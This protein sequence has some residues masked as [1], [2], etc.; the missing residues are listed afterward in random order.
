MNLKGKALGLAA[1]AAIAFG[2]AGSVSAE[3][4]TAD[5]DPNPTGQCSA[6]V[7]GGNIDFGTY[8]WN[9]SGYAAPGTTPSFSLSI[10]QNIAP[11]AVCDVAVQ[12]TDLDGPGTSSIPVGQVTLSPQGTGSVA[13]FTLATTD[14][15]LY[16]DT[17]GTQTVDAS[18]N[19]GALALLPTGTYTGTLTFTATLATP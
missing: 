6:A 14:H 5:L 7:S 19:T 4:T 3:T 18:I 17:T 2:F 11:E 15:S 10:T 8:T 16:T 9:G 13:P 12:G 1:A